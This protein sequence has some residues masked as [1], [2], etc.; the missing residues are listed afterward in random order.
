MRT[1]T[2]RTLALL[3][4]L[5]AMAGS[6]LA[7]SPVGSAADPPPRSPASPPVPDRSAAATWS[8]SA[9]TT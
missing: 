1:L 5:L 8:P 3:A 7:V 6:Y 9:A 4:L 2:V